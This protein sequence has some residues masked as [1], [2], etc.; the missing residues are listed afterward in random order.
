MAVNEQ[1][2]PVQE[3]VQEE[4]PVAEEVEE[5][6][7]VD[8]ESMALVNTVTGEVVG[9]QETPP[10][11]VEDVELAKWIGERLTYHKG[12]VEALKAEKAVWIDT[13]NKRFDQRIKNHTGAQGWFEFKYGSILYALA[14]RLIGAGKKRSVAVGLLMLKLRKTS[15]KMEVVNVG[16]ALAWLKAAGLTDAIKTTESVLVSQLPADL[17]TKLVNPKN[18]EKTGLKFSPG[19]EETLKIE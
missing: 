11:D 1:E 14:T 8:E 4:T 12:R 9:Y 17:K 2:I 15:A 3:E 5:I 19:G 6:I 13:I 10:E 18:V 16:K 7:I